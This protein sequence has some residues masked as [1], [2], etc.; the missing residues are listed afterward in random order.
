MCILGRGA[1]IYCYIEG[2][3]KAPTL[4]LACMCVGIYRNCALFYC[5]PFSFI[6][7][8]SRCI[9]YDA[10]G[11]KSRSAFCKVAGNYNHNAYKS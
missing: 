8:L 6:C 10:K 9:K 11:G 3:F 5:I 2:N 7:S 1:G 4:L